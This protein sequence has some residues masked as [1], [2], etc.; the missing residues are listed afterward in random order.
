MPAAN[1]VNSLPAPHGI[2][3]AENIWSDLRLV[4]SVL[5]ERVTGLP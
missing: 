4:S 2:S 3:G 1:N 5:A